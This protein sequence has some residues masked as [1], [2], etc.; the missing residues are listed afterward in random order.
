MEKSI[1]NNIKESI[2]NIDWKSKTFENKALDLCTYI[3]NLYAQEGGDFNL[4][5]SLSYNYFKKIIKTKSYIYPIKNK[6]IENGI[7]ESHNS[8]SYNVKKG[9]GKL[10]RFNQELISG[11]YVTLCC[12]KSNNDVTLCCPKINF[13]GLTQSENITKLINYKSSQYHICYPKSISLTTSDL[14]KL[15]FRPEV[16]DFIDE[17]SLTEKDIKCNNEIENEFINLKL[18]NDNWRIKKETGLKFAL[19][20]ELDLILYKDKCYLENKEDFLIRKTNELKLIYKKSVFEIE[21]GIYRISRNDTNKRLDYNLTNM[22][23]SLLDFLLCDGEPLI[24]LD[25]ANAQ[26][27]ILA[28]ITQDL[29]EEFINKA[30]S[31]EL[32]S[33]NKKEWFRIAF[34]KIKKDQDN[35]REKFPKTMKFIDSYKKEFG[36]KSFSNLLQNTESL[37]MID[38]LLPLLEDFDVY[39]IHDAI[40]V[41]ESQ[42]NEVKKITEE[43]FNEINFKC[44]LRN[45]KEETQEINFKGFKKLEI[46]KVSIEDKRLF[47]RKVNELRENNLEP[48]EDIFY[49]LNLWSREKTWFIYHKWLIANKNKK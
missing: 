25:I 27:A 43:F 24:E 23:S 1:L 34:D 3:F 32:Y 46:D 17:F 35:F 38:G 13:C 39:P 36:Y 28:F 31:G 22:K 45:K 21:N 2:S 41:K 5:K 9:K 42:L 18:E 6:L 10:Y 30:Q 29:D 37:I 7:L 8:N 12:P 11:D 49:S 4:Y 16:N 44:L 40:R 26:F 47:I 48:S 14:Q 20:Q 19:E 15:S 33:D